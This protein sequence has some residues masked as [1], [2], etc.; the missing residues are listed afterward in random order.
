MHRLVLPREPV[1]LADDGDGAELDQVLYVL[2]D[3]ADLGAIAVRPGHHH[4]A[5]GGQLGLQDPVGDRGDSQPLAMQRARI[6]HRRLRIG[7]VAALD[8]VPDGHV[9][10]ELRVA[11][12]GQVV[13]EQAGGNGAAPSRHSPVRAEWCPVRV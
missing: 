6:K 1:Q 7:A 2:A 8:P 4:V 9:H 10:V 5:E 11:V 3:A 13:Q 12:P